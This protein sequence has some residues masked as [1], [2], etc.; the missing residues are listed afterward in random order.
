MDKLVEHYGVV[1]SESTIARI[2]EGHAKKIFES[3]PPPQGWPTQPGTSTAVIVQ[4]D[5][6]MVPIME[7][8]VNSEPCPTRYEPERGAYFQ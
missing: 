1:L 6:G 2:T 8:D 5:G 7:P 3:A 4:T